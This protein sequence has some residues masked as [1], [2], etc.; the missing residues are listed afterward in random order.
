MF[1][2]DVTGYVTK[3]PKMESSTYARYLRMTVP[4]TVGYGEKART[5]FVQNTFF[6][7]DADRIINAKVK[8]GSLIKIVGTF[9][10]FSIF[11]SE[12]KNVTYK[13]IKCLGLNW[14]FIGTKKESPNAGTQTSTAAPQ[15][16]VQQ[17]QPPVAA[18]PGAGYA[19]SGLPGMQQ[20]VAQP[21]QPKQQQ[22]YAADP[23]LVAAANAGVSGYDYTL[24]PDEDL[25]F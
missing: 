1:V 14:T 8:K 18:T 10:D 6:N 3:D 21:P 5:F 17:Q 7:E 25:P 20:T 24:E 16:V 9:D 19:P 13:M 4:I 11:V 2:I 12:E 22:Q 23:V 15:P